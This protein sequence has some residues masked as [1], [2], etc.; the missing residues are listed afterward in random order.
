MCGVGELPTLVT[1]VMDSNDRLTQRLEIVR[2]SSRLGPKTRD[3]FTR[4]VTL[5]FGLSL[6][7]VRLEDGFDRGGEVADPSV[8]APLAEAVILRTASVSQAAS[9]EQ[10]TAE[11]PEPFET[12]IGVRPRG[13]HTR[14]TEPHEA[15]ADYGMHRRYRAPG[16]SRP[17]SEGPSPC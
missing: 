11:S 10:A 15:C 17:C 1:H 13:C 16:Q 6:F 9:R 12:S 14:V 2:R 3:S 7:Q 4:A 5:I 8:Q